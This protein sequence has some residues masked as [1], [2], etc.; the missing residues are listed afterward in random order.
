MEWTESIR[1]AI[2]YIEDHLLDHISAE[3]VANEVHISSFY[4]QKGFKFMTGYSIGEYI[5]C[6]RLYLA[7]LDIIVDKEKTIEIAY[8]YGYDTPES[9]T[10]AFSRFH[11]CSPMQL[12]K[13]IIRMNVFL[14][15]KI[16]II[17]QGG[18]DMDYVVEKMQGFKVIG[19]KKE[20]SFDNAYKEI[21]KFWDEFREKYCTG[22]LEGEIQQVI[23]DCHIGEYGICIDNTGK[24]G[25]FCYLIAGTYNGENVPNGMT[26]FEFPDMEW[27]KFACKGPMPGALQSVNT[28]IF[29]EWLPGS[30]D[31][32]IGMG[33]NIEWYAKGDIESV[34]YKSGIWIPVSKKA[35]K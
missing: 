12:K 26:V 21:P 23:Q 4:L 9:F 34:D 22:K 7:A 11:G 5:R 3:D 6:R 25:K 18:N 10:K 20:F 24:E 15:L 33:V 14:P 16:K 35:S 31:Y 1:S 27:A 28:K 17:I 2:G 8:K 19:F 32:E 13:D 29:N 30:P